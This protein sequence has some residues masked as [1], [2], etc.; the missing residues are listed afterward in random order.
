MNRQLGEKA[1]LAQDATP[2]EAENKGGEPEAIFLTTDDEV[3]SVTQSSPAGVGE[4]VQKEVSVEPRRIS[5]PRPVRPQQN[6][7]IHLS[8]ERLRPRPTR[9]RSKPK[10]RHRLRP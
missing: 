10:P 4:A 9:S 3:Q 5:C 7:T 8:R 6:L 2:A 1:D